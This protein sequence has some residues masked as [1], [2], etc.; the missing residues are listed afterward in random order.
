MFSVTGVIVYWFMTCWTLSIPIPKLRRA[1]EVQMIVTPPIII[2]K[3]FQFA[4]LWIVLLISRV[5]GLFVFCMVTGRGHAH[6]ALYDVEPKHGS[7]LSWGMVRIAS[8]LQA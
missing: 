2:G 4:Y 1:Y 5:A 7:A 3:F 6:Q 8:R